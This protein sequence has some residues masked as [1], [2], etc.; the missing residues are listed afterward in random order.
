LSPEYALPARPQSFE[1]EIAQMRDLYPSDGL[2]ELRTTV[3]DRL[4]IT[5]RA[6]SVQPRGSQS[7][8]HGRSPLLLTR[9]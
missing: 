4:S 6:R 2:V 1:I 3:R 9:D 8:I 5:L 7:D